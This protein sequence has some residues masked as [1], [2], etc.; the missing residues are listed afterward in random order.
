MITGKERVCVQGMGKYGT[1]HA[2]KMKAYGTNIVCGVSKG[3]KLMDTDGIPVLNSMKD[4]VIKY[5]VDT[6]VVFVPAMYAKDAVL[7]SIDAGIKKIVIITEH[8]PQYD[9]LHLYHVAKEK[10]VR[11]IG[12]NCPGLILP[13]ISKIGIMP[14]KAFVPGDIAVISKS[15]TLMYEVSNYLSL[16]SSGIKVAIGLGGDPITGTSIAEVFDWLI[17]E[18]VTKVRIIGELGGNEEIDGIQH[19]LDIGYKGE[20]KVFFA[21]RFAPRGKRMGHAGAI[22]LGYFGSVEYKERELKKLGITVAQTIP[23]LI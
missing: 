19:A 21:G 3:N 18:N 6:S 9:A 2:L 4:A 22:V 7:E 8:I 17:K 15:G 20:I 13:G 10:N 5:D 12:P 14:E 11:I 16:H 23:E 1:F